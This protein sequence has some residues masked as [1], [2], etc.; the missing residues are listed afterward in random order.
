M[1][2]VRYLNL[3][4]VDLATFGLAIAAVMHKA[5]SPIDS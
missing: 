5:D 2:R 3:K 1:K 4:D